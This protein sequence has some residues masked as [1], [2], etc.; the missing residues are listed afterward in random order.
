MISYHIILYPKPIRVLT[1]V[2]MLAAECYDRVT[3]KSFPT[4]FQIER[5]WCSLVLWGFGFRVWGFRVR[6]R[7]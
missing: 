4:V 6:F 1:G 5:V 2:G 7:I 3:V